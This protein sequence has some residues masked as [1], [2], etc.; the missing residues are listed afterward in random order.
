MYH[1]EPYKCVAG[2]NGEISDSS[3]AFNSSPN[4]R[5]EPPY[6]VSELEKFPGVTKGYFSMD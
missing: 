4:S 5:E 3:K 1:K 2:E 6:G